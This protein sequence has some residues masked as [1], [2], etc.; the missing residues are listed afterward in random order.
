MRY[1]VREP[2]GRGGMGVVE[3]AI[4]P[5]GRRVACKRVALHG[6][7]TALAQARARVRREAEVLARLH[8]PGIVGL[9]DV[10]DDGGDLVLVMPLLTGGSLSDVVREHGPLSPGQVRA[11]APPLLAALA[12]AHRQGVVHR[13]IKPANVLFDDA[14]RPH[15]ADFGIARLRDATPGLTSAGTLLG[16]P[17]FMAPEQARGEPAG[18]ASDVF[19][20]GATLRWALTGS[21][22][23]GH[24]DPRAVVGRA[25]SGRVE[26]LGRDVPDD[27][28]HLLVAMLRRRP[29]RRPTAAALAGGPAGTQV[30]RPPRRRPR[31]ALVAAAAA[32]V[33]VV[34]VAAALAGLAARPPTEVA[35]PPEAAPGC[36][37]LPYQPCGQPVAPWTD[38][39]TCVAD[40]ADY[41]GD[42]TNGCEAAPDDLDGTDLGRDEPLAATLVPADDVDR[43]PVAVVDA[44]HLT[45]DGTLR[46][47]IEGP[48]GTDVRLDVLDG[49]RVL[50]SAT[51]RD[52]ARAE[53]ALVEPRCLGDD[54]TTLEAR[55]SWAG[56]ARRGAAYRLERTGS[57]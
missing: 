42:A 45:C 30:L 32:L 53:V 16:T 26:H 48:A 51:S 25:A 3:A 40:H 57:W 39:R 18:P 6:S 31:W 19:A 35:A 22:P 41:D 7:A 36:L 55:V 37:D 24:G 44:L 34:A 28:R 52:G 20:L 50:G 12:A 21:G 46:V 23:W 8:H 4:A 27:L 15:L 43:Y 38:G 9:L 1:Q 47:S 54:A 5:D 10:V 2:L 11:M 17:D 14:G 13:D 56:E 33:A 49:D 29:E